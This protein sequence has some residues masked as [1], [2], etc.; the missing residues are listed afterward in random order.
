MERAWAESNTPM[1][2]EEQYRKELNGI[3]KQ[4]VGAS[5]DAVTFRIVT[6]DLISSPPSFE[7]K[8]P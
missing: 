1:E 6:S 4:L 3:R 2:K 7:V 5:S 8:L